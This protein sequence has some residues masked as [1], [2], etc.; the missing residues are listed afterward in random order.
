MAAHGS[1]LRR[2]LSRVRGVAVVA[3]AATAL[4]IVAASEAHGA[5]M[6]GRVADGRIPA[7]GA[8]QAV[9]KAVALETGRIVAS[10]DARPSG[11]W[12]LR[13]PNGVY[14]VLTTVVRENAAPRRAITPVVRIKG[15]AVR[16]IRVSLKR[17]RAPTVR[18]RASNARPASFPGTTPGAP[19][20]AVKALKGSSPSGL[21]RGFADLTIVDLVAGGDG[22][23]C[24]PPVVEWERRADVI[25]EIEFSNSRF[26]DP[27]TRI[28]RGRLLE[29]ELFVE[30]SIAEGADGSVSWAIQLRDAKT[31]KV[32]GGDTTAIPP[33]GDFFEAQSQAAQRLLDQICGGTYDINVNVATDASFATHAATG[34]LDATLTAT[35]PKVRFSPP[36]A[37]TATTTAGYSAVAW[38]SRTDCGYASDA[39]APGT[40]RFDLA[41]LPSGRLRVRWETPV[42]IRALGTASCPMAPPIPGQPGPSLMLPSPLEFEMSADG[43][44]QPI[45]GGF[46]SGG[47]GWVHSGAI[48]I[49]RRPPR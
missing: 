19:I 18:R 16:G 36:Q 42:G 48:T 12:S 22:S 9:V 24:V 26:A 49:A 37:F 25:A 31:G 41:I 39:T 40:L 43:G 3:L 14:A 4:S 38:T 34:I 2:G 28:P 45:A 1:G 13:V 5:L 17:T 47:D 21:G 29:P 32:V 33:G 35:G 8:G 15:R 20:V 6:S 7:A 23:R 30:G 44:Q 27:A 46:T 11:A 10:T